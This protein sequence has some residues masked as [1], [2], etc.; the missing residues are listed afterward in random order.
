MAIGKSYA[1]RPDD[2]EAIAQNLLDTLYGYKDG[3]DVLFKPMKASAVPFRPTEI[4]ALSYFVEGVIPEDTGF[5]LMPWKAVRFDNN[6]SPRGCS[7][8]EDSATCMGEYYFT[9]HH[10]DVTK[11]EYTFQYKKGSAGDV[12]IVTHHSS[13][14]YKAAGGP[15]IP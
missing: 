5:A 4:E 9:D 15:F 1:L 13:F 12:K 10:D 2:Y 7:F 11:V 3:F 14:P 6:A 8:D